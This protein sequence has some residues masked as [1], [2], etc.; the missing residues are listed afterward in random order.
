MI[1]EYRY[2]ILSEEM[3]NKMEIKGNDNKS[4]I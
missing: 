3:Q 2:T 4:L 1:W